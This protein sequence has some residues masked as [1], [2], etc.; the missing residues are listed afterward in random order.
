MPVQ[1]QIRNSICAFIAT[2]VFFAGS[3]APA[4]EPADWT[5]ANLPPLLQLYRHLHQH[6]ELSFAE[7]QT[8]SRLA[9]E[10]RKTGATVTT[11]LGGHGVVGLLKNGAGPTLMLRCDM[12]GLP[13]EEK[14]ELVYASKVRVRDA[15]GTEVGVMHACGHDIHMTNLVGVAQYLHQNRDLWRGS[16]MLV[17]QPAEERGAGAKAMLDDG[18]FQRFPKPDFA[19]AMHVDSELATG[20]VGYRPGYACANVDT[21]T[22]TM[23][24][25][26]GHGA[27]PHTTID[28]VVMAAQLVLDLQTIVSREIKPTDPAVVTVG[29]I[30]GG[31]KSNIIGDKCQLQL[32]VRSY[33]DEVRDHLAKAIRRKALAVAEG[34]GATPP[35]VEYRRGTPSLRNDDKLVGRVLK[36]FQ[37]QLGAENVVFS[38]PTMGGEDFSRYGR[39]GVPIFMYRVG[40]VSPKRLAGWARIEQRPPSLHSAVYYPDAEQTLQTSVS[41][42][43]AA[44]VE[45]LKPA[46]QTAPK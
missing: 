36:A 12:D 22:I 23:V 24:G 2:T 14:T 25:R 4:A 43:A 17:C 20:K 31:T 19:L 30:H 29:T 37:R 42:M 35:L 18:L 27:Q 8:A 46:A 7:Q 44:A 9:D 10:L 16:A 3:A 21:V 39:A 32:T 5:R 40:S 41:V 6:P 45:L 13:V 15:S 33:S 28:P 38:E 34:A 26:G 1:R 11:K